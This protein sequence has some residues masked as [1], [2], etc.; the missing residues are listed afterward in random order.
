MVVLRW[1]LYWYWPVGLW[2]RVV[3]IEL[4]VGRFGVIVRLLLSRFWAFV[5]DRGGDEEGKRLVFIYL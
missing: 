5:R 4:I 3:E 2:W 1:A